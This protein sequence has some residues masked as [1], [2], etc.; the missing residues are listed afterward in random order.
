MSNV[1]V[2]KLLS[3]NKSTVKRYK[4]I[5]REEGRITP[6]PST[7]KPP[8]IKAEEY[9]ELRELVA[10]RTDWTLKTLAQAWH[11]RKSILVSVS[12]MSDTCMRCGLTFKKS[13]LSPKSEMSAKDGNF[14]PNET[15]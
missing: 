13:R 10:A 8:F 4:K 12:V 2:A 11:E 9:S 3:V 15:N 1:A 7:G 14:K 5:W 6:L